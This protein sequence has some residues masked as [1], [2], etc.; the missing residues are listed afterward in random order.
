M[1]VNTRTRLGCAP[2]GPWLGVPDS[3]TRCRPGGPRPGPRRGA[4]R[5]CGRGRGGQPEPEITLSATVG[6]L[7]SPSR[8]LT[9]LL[10]GRSLT[11]TRKTLE[12]HA[13]GKSARTSSWSLRGRYIALALQVTGPGLS[14]ALKTDNRQAGGTGMCRAEVR[15]C[16]MLRMRAFKFKLLASMSHRLVECDELEAVIQII[17]HV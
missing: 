11:P 2:P 10:R 13:A 6:R 15:I 3:A 4:R 12:P 1:R 7:A 8:V 5:G 14:C 16:L 9:E 17:P